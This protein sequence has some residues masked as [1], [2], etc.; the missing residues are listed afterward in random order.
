MMST[1]TEKKVLQRSYSSTSFPANYL[2]ANQQ[3]SDFHIS[4]STHQHRIGSNHNFSNP[5]Q[6][7]HAVDP[8]QALYDDIQQ[9]RLS[10]AHLTQSRPPPEKQ[11][12]FRTFHPSWQ[13]SIFDSISSVHRYDAPK[14]HSSQIGEQFASPK[15]EDRGQ[16]SG[17][18]DWSFGRWEVGSPLTGGT[19]W[20]LAPEEKA[21]LSEDFAKLVADAAEKRR[22]SLPASSIPTPADLWPSA[23]TSPYLANPAPPLANGFSHSATTAS[24]SPWSSLQ[25]S[26]SRSSS[27]RRFVKPADRARRRTLQ[28][29]SGLS[30]P[31]L[32]EE[33]EEGADS[34]S[35]FGSSRRNS[36]N[37][38]STTTTTT[39]DSL[40]SVNLDRYRQTEQ[41]SSTRSRFSEA[42]QPTM[43]C[44]A[45]RA[46]E[47]PRRPSYSDALYSSRSSSAFPSSSLG[48]ASSDDKSFERFFTTAAARPSLSSDSSVV[49]PHSTWSEGGLPHQQEERQQLLPSKQSHSF[50]RHQSLKLLQDIELRRN[51]HQQDNMASDTSSNKSAYVSPYVRARLKAQEPASQQ[52]TLIAQPSTPQGGNGHNTVSRQDS[53]HDSSATSKPAAE[54]PSALT[55]SSR[56]GKQTA[57]G[58]RRRDPR[59]LSLVDYNAFLPD[60]KTENDE[61]ARAQQH[62]EQGR[63]WATALP[64]TVSS[65]PLVPVPVSAPRNPKLPY[66]HSF[67]VTFPLPH[68]EL[69]EADQRLPSDQKVAAATLAD[70]P[71][72]SPEAIDSGSSALPLPFVPQDGATLS[73]LFQGSHSP[74]E[75]LSLPQPREASHL[76]LGGRTDG[77]QLT[78]STLL[79]NGHSQRLP[80][81]KSTGNKS[82]SGGKTVLADG[83]G[84]LLY[85][86]G[87]IVGNYE[88]LGTLGEGTFGK[89]VRAKASLIADPNTGEEK[90]KVVAL[91]VIRNVEKYREA[92]KLE[93]NVLRTLKRKDPTGVYLCVQMLDFFD[94]YGH[95]CIAFDM[96]GKSVF[97]FLKENGYSPFPME[98]V[99]Y[100]IYQLCHAVS[101]LHG[102]QLTHTD[103]KPENMLFVRDEYDLVANPSKGKRNSA[104]VLRGTYSSGSPVLRR[105]KDASIQLIDFGSATFDDEHHSTVISTRHYRAP[106]VI[107][108]LG[109]SQ[110]CDV[111][112]IGCILF[113]LFTGVTLFQ[114]HDNLEHLAMMERIL[115][116]LPHRMCKRTRT[117]FYVDGKL[118]W[119]SRSAD[120]LYVRDNCK[121]LM[122]YVNVTQEDERHLFDL[123]SRM[124]EYE[125]S[126][127]IKVQDALLHPFFDKIEASKK[128]NPA[129][130]R[131]S[132]SSQEATSQNSRL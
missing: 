34:L 82:S 80:F 103:L 121:P 4:S 128:V 36:R 67:D 118:D 91:K 84:H 41:R 94:H 18:T 100:I 97:D 109:W 51:L 58:K 23:Y 47:R 69:T 5:Y 112:S 43:G 93:I 19:P 22:A 110:P 3:P 72:S 6:S 25:S 39:T 17:S 66:S 60:E 30:A 99:R 14:A 26:S 130:A 124:L 11:A 102:C 62:K 68:I 76:S 9:T 108:E 12:S 71:P 107:L 15:K 98:Q 95:I 28:T 73:I 45:S 33:A 85:R 96:L 7:Y 114:T 24:S 111:W 106:E 116:P 50:D 79:P 13:E 53:R 89:V 65:L 61:G 131:R 115:G 38:S 104:E 86:P 44:V 119:D 120:A 29:Y 70:V 1:R 27:Q 57:A 74:K 37:Y 32:Y 125:P 42:P 2:T 55:S 127:R 81:K 20:R 92:A 54:S 31:S 8:I 59:F 40:V 126:A 63:P 117:P 77:Q 87:D 78:E 129:Q 90:Q 122:R 52:S 113:E 75:D 83:D 46:A 21:Q 56:S 49:D 105:V 123:I 88:I 64:A 132:S 35:N 101:F 16:T 48:V 10:H